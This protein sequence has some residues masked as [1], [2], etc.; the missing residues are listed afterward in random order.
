MATK[1]TS[2]V[3]KRSTATTRKTASSN[4]YSTGKQ[5]TFLSNHGHVLI[6]LARNPQARVRDIAEAIGITERSTQGILADLE[7]TGYLVKKK[8]GRRNEYVIKLD[9]KF[10]HPSESHKAIR[11]L[12]EIFD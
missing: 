1:K 7:A 6:F 5:W 3:N 10:R 12:L 11:H 8:V 4:E 9:K 2:A